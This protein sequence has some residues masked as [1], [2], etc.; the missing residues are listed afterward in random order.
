MNI[1][2]YKHTTHNDRMNI[3]LDEYSIEF[4]LN[5]NGLYDF[6]PDGDFSSTELF[7]SYNILFPKALYFE[8]MH[9][10]W[11]STQYYEKDDNYYIEGIQQSTTMVLLN[12][13][14]ILNN[15]KQSMYDDNID[16]EADLHLLVDSYFILK[17]LQTPDWVKKVNDY[18]FNR[19][20]QFEVNVA[21]MKTAGLLQ[22]HSDGSYSS[23]LLNI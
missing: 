8:L 14:D 21:T 15:K 1:N 18:M 23:I 3:D 6:I 4:V 19:L 22:K 7:A 5:K 11:Y 10:M 9:K 12:M 13:F 2:I 17:L 16:N 20:T